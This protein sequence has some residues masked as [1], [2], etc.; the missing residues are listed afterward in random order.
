MI[1]RVSARARVWP[2]RLS[3][4]MMRVLVGVPSIPPGAGSRAARAPSLTRALASETA[5]LRAR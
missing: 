2:R 4:P 1:I 5:P 3:A